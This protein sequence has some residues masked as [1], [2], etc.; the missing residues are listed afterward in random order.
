MAC[1]CAALTLTLG[2]ALWNY[3]TREV[4]AAEVPSVLRLKGL[5]IE[6]N[7]GRARVLLGAPFPV[8]RDRLRQDSTSTTMLF[9]DE[10]GHDRFSIGQGINP[11][12]IKGKVP[13]HIHRIGNATGYGLTIYD[14]QGNE[15]G[16]MGFL[17]NGSTVNRATFALDRPGGDAIGAMVD[18]TTG[19]AGL[20]ALYPRNVASD[21]NGVLLGTQEDKAFVTL[22]D[23]HDRERATYEIGPSQIP[24]L[25]VFDEQGKPGSNLLKPDASGSN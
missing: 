10:E 16:G 22:K 25:R 21:V 9:L 15:R 6:D 1:L 7:Q 14:P 20:V 24:F 5:I 2:F 17:S 18:D 19:F 13:P 8:V 4:R 3:P 11:P 12:Q 23:A